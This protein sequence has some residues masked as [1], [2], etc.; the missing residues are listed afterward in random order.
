MA[1]YVNGIRRDGAGNRKRPIQ[2]DFSQIASSDV[3][4][5]TVESGDEA[6]YTVLRDSA[7]KIISVISPDGHEI[8]IDWP[9]G[10]D[11]YSFLAG[12]SMGR[13]MQ[14]VTIIG[15]SFLSDLSRWIWLHYSDAVA[16][17]TYDINTQTCTAQ[18]CTGSHFDR[19]YLEHRVQNVDARCKLSFDLTMPEG[20]PD[21][22]Y[23]GEDDYIAALTEAPSTME[24]DYYAYRADVIAEV[25]YANVCR[26]KRKHHFEMIF[27]PPS[28]QA[29]FLCI[30]MGYL[31]DR[32]PF[33]FILENMDIQPYYG[34]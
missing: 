31:T 16:E 21:I 30:D 34:E 9:E 29:V 25:A 24:R 11:E 5:E 4:T 28:S 19:F 6:Q 1:I 12:L 14:G 3:F 20:V 15:A 18:I 32:I 17:L 33:T 8:G 7:N 22:A 2:F 13:S 10:Y 26:D 23:G 27:T